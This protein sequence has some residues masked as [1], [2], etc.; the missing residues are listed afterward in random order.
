MAEPKNLKHSLASLSLAEL[1]ELVTEAEVLIAEKE[2]GEKSALVAEIEQLTKARG[3][4]VADILPLF[5][6]LP[7]SRATEKPKGKGGKGG[8]GT[9]AP[10]YRNPANPAETWS[11]RGR[12]PAWVQTHVA[13]GGKVEDLAIAPQVAG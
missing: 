12:Q 1:R 7:V 10:K 11:G 3:F 2:Q 13:G 8:R 9:V 5:P 4:A 6:G